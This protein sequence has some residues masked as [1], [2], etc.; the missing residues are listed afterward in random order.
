MKGL[1]SEPC[2]CAFQEEEDK[3]SDDDDYVPYVPLKERRR[4][5]V[6]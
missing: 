3:L 1:N 4:L 6:Q 2:P 5:E